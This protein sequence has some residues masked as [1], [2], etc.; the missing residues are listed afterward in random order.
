MAQGLKIAPSSPLQLG[1]I[2]YWNLLPLKHELERLAGDEIE[3][4]R[5]HPSVV[6]KWL[7]E[8][9]VAIAPSS[10]VCLVKNSSNEIALPLGIASVG[11]VQSV[12]I[13]LHHENVALLEAIRTRQHQLRELVKQG[14][15]RH[16]CDARSVAAFVWK[17]AA[18]LPPMVID[19]APPP[20]HVTPASATSGMLSRILYRLWFGEE[21]H[22]G[23]SM[24]RPLEVL[25]G[26][27]ALQ[28]K[29]T[30]RAVI[31]LGEAWR[32]LTELPFVYAVWQTSK[33]PLG[34]YWRQKMFEAAEIAQARMRVE[35]TYYLADLAAADVN[36]HT[37]DLGAYWKT[38]QYRLSAPH[39]K[40][41]ALFLALARQLVPDAVDDQAVANIMRWET[42]AES[43]SALA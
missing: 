7:Q 27:E 8:G 15:A 17:A 25:I 2:P 13:G 1:W 29:A 16:Q 18:Q 35:P 38:I 21:P 14:Q 36:G 24:R 33:R 23:V 30:F 5:G 19:G 40:G 39:F 28:K 4:H 43:A 9:K 20:L 6:N 32:D 26:D 31:D 12:Y 34:S 3:F 42:F 37:I 10:S 41:L 22:S 11:A